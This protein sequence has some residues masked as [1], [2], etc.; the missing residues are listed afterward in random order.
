M[1]HSP[2]LDRKLSVCQTVSKDFLHFVLGFCY[3][4][5]LVELCVHFPLL[6]E[7]ISIQC[8]FLTRGECVKHVRYVSS[9]KL[10]LKCILQF[11][12]FTPPFLSKLCPLNDRKN[13]LYNT[14][15]IKQYV[16]CLDTLHAAVQ[17]APKLE[18]TSK[19]KGQ[20]E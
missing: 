12:V 15:Q 5:F 11:S 16:C 14:L 9:C 1:F 13:K 4:Y 2:L 3:D 8:V 18:R 19:L 7:T 10:I 6:P 20:N 17:S